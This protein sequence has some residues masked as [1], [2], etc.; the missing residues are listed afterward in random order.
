MIYVLVLGV[1]FAVGVDVL[2]LRH[3]TRPRLM[4]NVGIVLAFAGCYLGF[5]KTLGGS[6]P[7]FGARSMF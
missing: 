2:S 3:H 6:R 4:V 5:R 7:A 1:V